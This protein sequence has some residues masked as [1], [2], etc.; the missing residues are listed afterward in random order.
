MLVD[1]L[2]M[3]FPEFVAIPR[4]GGDIEPTDMLGVRLCESPAVFRIKPL[5]KR[6]ERLD[7]LWRVSRVVGRCVFEGREIR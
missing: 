7:R 6:T 1:I 2:A 5:R 4:N 3:L